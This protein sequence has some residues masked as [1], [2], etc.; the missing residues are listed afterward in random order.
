MHPPRTPAVV[1]AAGLLFLTVSG[2][3]GGPAP[4]P[5][6]STAP[7]AAVAIPSVNTDVGPGAPGIAVTGVT[8]AAGSTTWDGAGVMVAYHRTN[9]DEQHP[10]RGDVNVRRCRLTIDG[11]SAPE[12]ADSTSLSPAAFAVVFT[13]GS[14]LSA[15]AH[16]LHVVMPLVGGG[17]V[18]CTW[19]ATS[20]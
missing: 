3:A 4:S 13:D 11:R 20:K 2:C 16:T 1:I 18:T 19:V 15:G 10:E 12:T 7:S 8:P 6:S 14:A 5:P 17:H 9:V